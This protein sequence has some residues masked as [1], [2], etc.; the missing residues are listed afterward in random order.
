MGA[1]KVDLDAVVVAFSDNA[2]E[3][4]Y[5]LDRETG[6]VFNLLED[7]DD[8]ETE[9]IVWQIEADGG[10]RFV[11]VPKLSMEEE[12]REQDSFVESLEE[13]D[14][15]KELSSVLESDRDGSRF[16]EFVSRHRAAREKWRA[17]LKVR[18]RERAYQWLESLG[19][20]AS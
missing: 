15:K 5:Y 17:F 19:I 18:S 6:Q 12:M 9:E 4:S 1:P 11:P 8:P 10:R 3:R 13:G 7:K 14:L 20:P 2:P 16:G